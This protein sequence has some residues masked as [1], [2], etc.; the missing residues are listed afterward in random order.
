[1][2]QWIE[3]GGIGDH[4]LLA[5]KSQRFDLVKLETENVKNDRYS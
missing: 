2:I 1:M 4:S 3:V 5:M